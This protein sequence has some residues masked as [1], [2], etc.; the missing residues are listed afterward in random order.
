MTTSE[1]QQLLT[2][3]YVERLGLLVRHEASAVVMGQYDINNAYQYVLNREETHVYW[4]RHAIV[5]QGGEIPADPPPATVPTRTETSTVAAEDARLNQAFVDKW[6]PRI[7]DVT[8]ARHKGMLNVM[9]NEMLEQRRFFE[10]AAA[11]RTDLLGTPM[12]IHERVGR[13]LPKRWVE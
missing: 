12:A 4:L 13:V 10:L 2:E 1:L 3:C 11:G 8:H 6:R 5:A 7:D 9:L